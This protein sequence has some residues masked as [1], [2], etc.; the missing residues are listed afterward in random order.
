MRKLF[1]IKFD[2]WEKGLSY[3]TT[4]FV[5]GIFQELKNCN[6]FE[7]RG[8]LTPTRIKYEIGSDVIDKTRLI[9]VVLPIYATNSDQFYALADYYKLYLIDGVDVSDISAQI[10]TGSQVAIDAL[11]WKGS[12]IYA[13]SGEVRSNSIP[14]SSANDALLLSVNPT[15][16][17]CIGPDRDL[18][19]G[20]GN[21]VAY[22]K[23]SGTG[24]AV[25]AYLET[26]NTVRRLISDGRYLVWVASDEQ[27]NSNGKNIITVAWWNMASS[28]FDQIYRFE[29]G[30]FGDANIIGT[31]IKIIT[32]TGIWVTNMDNPPYLAVPFG[33][34]LATSDIPDRFSKTMSTYKGNTMFWGNW[35][36]KIYAYGNRIGRQADRLFQPYTV[37]SRIYAIDSNGTLL[38]TSSG[39]A[40]AGSLYLEYTPL[41]LPASSV[42]AN[43]AIA[44]LAGF[45]LGRPFTF[46]SAKILLKNP[47][48]SGDSVSLQILSSSSTKTILASTT[49]TNDTDSGERSLSFDH[50]EVG[51]GNDMEVFEDVSD[52]KITTNV[53]IL[54]LTIYGKEADERSTYVKSS[55]V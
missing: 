50:K 33:G 51:G 31:T 49:K 54:S 39:T 41:S 10:G 22:V 17:L 20:V 46:H 23:S 34:T 37:Y 25:A 36:G 15:S 8:A 21:N 52:V 19:V 40:G 43:T 24:V 35:N 12:F 9:R 47:I 29:G 44:N 1:E 42:Y 2:E 18:Y 30:T 3:E 32:S 6:P 16:N 55:Y 48:V 11:K 28:D 26:N 4:A 14:V 7:G 53:P 38:I 13:M 27:T 45:S 5:G